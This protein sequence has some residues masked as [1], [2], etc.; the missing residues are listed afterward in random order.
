M[1]VSLVVLVVFSI[2]TLLIFV[3]YC[4]FKKKI[5]ESVSAF[6]TLNSDVQQ[7]SLASSSKESQSQPKS[8]APV[9]KE[10]QPRSEKQ[11]AE[12]K[13]STTDTRRKADVFSV[14]PRSP[15]PPPASQ[16]LLM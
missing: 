12:E 16:T 10:S 5:L 1:S 3:A 7:Q 9:S 4:Y 6:S 8:S 14:H 2:T 11:K 13:R 15:I